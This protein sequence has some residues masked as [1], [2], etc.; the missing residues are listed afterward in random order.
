MNVTRYKTAAC[1]LLL[2][3][4]LP[5][6]SCSTISTFHTETF[7][8]TASL[9]ARTIV[10]MGHGTER[11]KIYESTAEDIIIEAETLYAIQKARVQNSI[12][13][14]QWN[15]LMEKDN[16]ILKGFFKEWKQKEKLSESVINTFKE[17]V[18]A[19]FDEILNLEGSKLKR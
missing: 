4:I 19:A 11:Y 12:S 14:A 9:K 6:F 13:I 15:L 2:L 10:L 16:S 8:R 1:S 5:V 18:S 7:T 3:L 17:Q